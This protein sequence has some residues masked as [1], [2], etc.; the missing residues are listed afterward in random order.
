MR[1]RPAPSCASRAP[2]R[3]PGR[4]PAPEA[5]PSGES[6]LEVTVARG[7]P[8][9]ASHSQAAAGQSPWDLDFGKWQIALPSGTVRV[10]RAPDC[11]VVVPSPRVSRY[12]AELSVDAQGARVRDLGS[13]NGTAVDGRPVREAELR[14][15]DRVAFG[16]VEA[17]LIERAAAG[18]DDAAD[19]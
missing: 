2:A 18:G 1:S 11:D 3:P 12:H 9:V 10:G 13:T 16:G 6:A 8:L 5:H 15:G 4:P 14:P 7:R 19:A 17:R